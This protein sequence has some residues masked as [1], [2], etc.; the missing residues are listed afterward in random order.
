MTDTR[1]YNAVVGFIGFCK[2]KKKDR[3]ESAYTPLRESCSF[4]IL[5]YIQPIYKMNLKFFL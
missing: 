3:I 2:K 5:D 1:I 4:S